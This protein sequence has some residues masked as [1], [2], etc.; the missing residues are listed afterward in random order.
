MASQAVDFVQYMRWVTGP[1][2]GGVPG[3]GPGAVPASQPSTPPL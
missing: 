1:A 2:G 3:G